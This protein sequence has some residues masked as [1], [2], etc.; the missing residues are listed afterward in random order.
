MLKL[1][2]SMFLDSTE[3]ILKEINRLQHKEQRTNGISCIPLIPLHQAVEARNL[4]VVEALLERGHNVNETDHR[5][6]TPLHIICSHPNKIGM[7]E[8]IAEKTKRDLSSYEERAISEACYNN[9]INIFKMLLLND[10]NRTIDD[11]QLCTIDYDDSI[12]TKII[13]LLLAYGADTKIKTEDK[14]KTALHYASTNKNYKLAE[15]LLIYGAEVNSPDIGNN[16]PMHEAVRHRNE[17]VV[18]ILL[19]Y[20]SNTDHMNSCGTTP[21][22]ISVG[23]VLNRNNYSI[24]KILLEH[25]TSVNIQS[26]ILGFTALHLSIHSE[27]KLNL[28][29]EYGADPNILNFEKETPLSMA[30]KVTRYDINIYNR[31]IYNICL[32]AF[33][34]PFI[35]TT[36]GYIKNMTCINGY[37]KCKSIKDACEYEIKNL[38]SIKLSPRFSMADFLKDDNSL[39]MDKII[40]NDLID[41]YY[42]FMDSFPIYG[43]IVK[44]SIDTAKDRYLLIQ[45]AIRS[46]DN[47]TFPSQRVSWY[48]MPL[49]IKHDIMYLLDDKSLC[50]LIVA[51]Y[52]S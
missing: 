20:G 31:L 13:K 3:H 48:N 17:D 38:E 51:E 16:S 9:D 12:D 34:Y 46:M 11:V 30:V 32:R 37:P 29:L 45:G 52:D 4:E 26:S 33:K 2:I 41:Y 5:Y 39:M 8:V 22:H 47:I 27:D 6:L 44:K 36:E 14:L 1:Y 25:G 42:S 18:K 24:L 15:Y 35:K 40:N 50:N 10:G 7:K 28:L 43:N 23:R 21:L 49:E 19:Q